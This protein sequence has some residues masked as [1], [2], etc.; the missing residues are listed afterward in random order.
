MSSER[1]T[2]IVVGS[3]VAGISAAVHL[4]KTSVAVT[5][6]EKAHRPGG[7][8][9]SLLDK[10]ISDWIDNGQ[11]VLMGCYKETLE[12]T[13][14]LNTSSLLQSLPP[15]RQVWLGEGGSRYILDGRGRIKP[16]GKLRGLLNFDA[17]GWRERW[18]ILRALRQIQRGGQDASL[19]QRTCLEWLKSLNQSN[20]A[21]GYFWEPIILATLNESP[22]RAAASL[23]EVVIRKTFL[24]DDE[25]NTILLPSGRLSDL[26]FP[27]AGEYIEKGG[28]SLHLASRAV[29]LMIEDDRAIG[30]CL[31]NGDKLLADSV[32]LAIPPDA[33]RRILNETPF[34]TQQIEE[35]LSQ[36]VYSP[37]ISVYLWLKK[38]AL[39]E[40]MVGFFDSPL[41]WGF[42]RPYREGQ[43]LCVVRSAA[44]EWSNLSAKEI[45]HETIRE[46]ERFL[47]GFSQEEYIH[48]RVIKQPKATPSLGPGSLPVRRLKGPLPE[49][50]FIAGDWTDTGLPATIESAA[51]SGR[52]CAE[53][54]LK[55]KKGWR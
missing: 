18:G 51:L 26:F 30:V 53:Q 42:S 20:T 9:F 37:I 34:E 15:F 10:E 8:T 38:P 54:I 31:R 7:R 43:R 19:E 39:S 48:S 16:W 5:L 32:V 11:H 36:F 4:A 21:I 27:A 14:I 50:L 46:L 40:P 3:G 55:T 24:A 49:G 41:Q 1:P 45:C 44:H 29:A 22:N 47:P 17:I 12:L 6:L 52:Q 23:L 25:A 35:D 13:R 2:A 33:L 28:G